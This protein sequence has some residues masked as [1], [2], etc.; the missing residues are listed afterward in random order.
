MDVLNT[1]VANQYQPQLGTFSIS[2]ASV[3]ATVI[4]FDFVSLINAHG[5]GSNVSAHYG[6][7]FLGMTWASA[8]LLLAG[9]AASFVNVFIRAARAVP[10]PAVEKDIEGDME[11]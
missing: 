4:A 1:T 6:D 11:G 9:S 5:E 10:A 7:K 8:G 3:I 2:I